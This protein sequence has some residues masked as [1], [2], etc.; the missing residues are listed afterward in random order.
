MVQFL[1][2]RTRALTDILD[3]LSESLALLHDRRTEQFYT[4]MRDSV[5]QRFE[6]SCDVFWKYLKDKLAQQ[7]GIVVANPRGVFREAH[8]QSIVNKDEYDTL[9]AM[10]SDRNDTSHK[11]DAQM[12]EEIAKRVFKYHELMCVVLKRL[13]NTQSV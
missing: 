8:E 12:A 5:I 10:I 1:N 3:R 11:Y 4:Q 9:E 2:E 7:Y 13:E 6:V